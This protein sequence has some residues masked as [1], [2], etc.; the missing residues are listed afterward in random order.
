MY[1]QLDIK[2]I[3]HQQLHQQKEQ[4]LEE[5]GRQKLNKVESK[6]AD[7]ISNLAKQNAE[8]LFGPMDR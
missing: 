2:L 4:Q 6:A 7:Q 8:I 1:G 3:E 5:R